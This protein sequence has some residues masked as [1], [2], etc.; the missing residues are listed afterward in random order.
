MMVT[1]VQ[2]QGQAN[3][4]QADQTSS[5]QSALK[6]GAKWTA[7]VGGGFLGAGVATVHGSAAVQGAV[8]WYFG[9]GIGANLMGYVAA[10]ASSKYLAT[11]GF[12]VGG[13]AGAATVL[14][15]TAATPYIVRGV[16]N[17]YNKAFSQETIDNTSSIWNFTMGVAEK[18]V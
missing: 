17:A 4:A 14:A 12:A 2:D 15:A 5:W 11:A 16:K 10:G 13:C 7:A 18:C 6:H 8:S 3:Q 9:G 1:S